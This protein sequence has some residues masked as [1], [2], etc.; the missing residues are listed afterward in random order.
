MPKKK[1]TYDSYIEPNRI[2]YVLLFLNV[3]IL[4]FKLLLA[5][6]FYK[7]KVD[8]KLF[9]LMLVYLLFYYSVITLSWS[10]K[11]LQSLNI[12]VSEFID[13]FIEHF[14][15]FVADVFIV[16]VLFF[17]RR[18]PELNTQPNVLKLFS[19]LMIMRAIIQF[20]RITQ[21]KKMHDNTDEYNKYITK[22]KMV[23]NIL[24]TSAGLILES[25]KSTTNA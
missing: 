23:D 12:I 11:R 15:V 19:M 2:N 13:K 21:I 3:I 24:A 25:N 18:Q 10:D 4:G 1:Q 14:S 7:Q 22:K 9:N 17:A 6:K 16:V 8:A 5:Y 20:W